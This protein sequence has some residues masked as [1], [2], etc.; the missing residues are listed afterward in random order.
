MKHS[1]HGKWVIPRFSSKVEIGFV[2]TGKANVYGEL[3][4]WFLFMVSL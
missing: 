2:S 4:S 1:C 3:F